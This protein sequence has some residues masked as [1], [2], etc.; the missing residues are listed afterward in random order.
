MIVWRCELNEVT[1]TV[2]VPAAVV[3]AT[4]VP[5]CVQLFDCRKSA[6]NALWN[7]PRNSPVV[8]WASCSVASRLCE[9]APLPLNGLDAK[10]VIP[11][12]REASIDTPSL[13]VP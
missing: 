5:D 12:D 2:V 3:T 13:P 10:P 1:G 8:N 7:R 9:F 11:L 6:L 4:V